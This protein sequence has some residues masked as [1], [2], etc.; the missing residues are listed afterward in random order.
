MF[1][2]NIG[3]KKFWNFNVETSTDCVIPASQNI[4]I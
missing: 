1:F 2:K 4:F 3:P